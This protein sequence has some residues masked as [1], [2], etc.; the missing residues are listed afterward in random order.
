[1]AEY[2]FTTYTKYWRPVT[3]RTALLTYIRRWLDR[4]G[5]T[6][7]DVTM[8][9]LFQ[10]QREDITVTNV[11]RGTTLQHEDLETERRR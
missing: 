1:M 7:T 4:E 5:I 9:Q 11:S 8:Q 2:R 10:P 6:Y 3:D